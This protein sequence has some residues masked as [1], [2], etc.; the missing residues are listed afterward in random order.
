[1]TPLEALAVG[2]PVVAHAVGGLVEALAGEPLGVLVDDLLLLARLDQGRPLERNPID[3]GRITRDA[4]DD[5]RT[6]APDRPIDFTA[7]APVVDAKK[8]PKVKLLGDPNGDRVVGKPLVA[9]R[10]L[11]DS[12]HDRFSLFVLRDLDLDR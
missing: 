2:T 11:R 6:V 3:L 10:R 9:C 4:I 1:M 7:P 5:L 8:F 12:V